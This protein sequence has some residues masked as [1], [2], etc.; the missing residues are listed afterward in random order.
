ML[1]DIKVENDEYPKHITAWFVNDDQYFSYK[2]I[3]LDKNNNASQSEKS[4]EDVEL[5]EKNGI[6]HFIM[7]NNDRSQATWAYSIYEITIQGNLS[8]GQIIEIIDSIY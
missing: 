7:T 6:S 4:A 1:E 5:Y 2:I 8:R 3:E